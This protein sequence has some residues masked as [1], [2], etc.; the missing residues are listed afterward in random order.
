[1]LENDTNYKKKLL[2]EY[3]KLNW[4]PPVYRLMMTKNDDKQINKKYYKTGVYDNDKNIIGMG[5]SSSKS[6]SE[7]LS[8]KN[9]LQYLN[10][11]ENNKDEIE[12][13]PNNSNIINF[14]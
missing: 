3:H 9:A 1:L 7:K 2:I 5:Y 12:E 6:T 8:A 11:L 10:V 13:I 14:K 4:N